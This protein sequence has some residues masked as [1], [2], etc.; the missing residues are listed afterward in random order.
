M[1]ATNFVLSPR[2]TRIFLKNKVHTSPTVD[3]F[4]QPTRKKKNI[5]I[6]FP[7]KKKSKY[8][9]ENCNVLRKSFTGTL[10]RLSFRT[11]RL[12][13]SLSR[14]TKQVLARRC[15]TAAAVL[16]IVFR[17]VTTLYYRRSV[18]SLRHTRVLLGIYIYIYICTYGKVI[19]WPWKT[20][21]PQDEV[22]PLFVCVVARSKLEGVVDE[23]K[24]VCV[25]ESSLHMGSLN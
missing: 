1:S 15:A 14:I 19:P 12:S 11:K 6:L 25:C 4:H 2:K 10:H 17:A 23:G 7:L 8:I 22:F 21:R 18:S 13:L 3:F 24:N 20:D 16:F 9:T 5:P